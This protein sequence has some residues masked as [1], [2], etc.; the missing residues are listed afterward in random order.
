MIIIILIG[1]IILES[2]FIEK[3][4]HR[5][6]I[7]TFTHLGSTSNF[8]SYNISVASI[9]LSHIVG[10]RTRRKFVGSCRVGDREYISLVSHIAKFIDIYFRIN[11]QDFLFSQISIFQYAQGKSSYGIGGHCR[12]IDN[13]SKKKPTSLDQD[14]R[15]K[16]FFDDAKWRFSFFETSQSRIGENAS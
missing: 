5:P 16:R 1:K 12:N 7:D 9:I 10:Q 6:T 11:C 4:N 8:S 13:S 3:D 2:G 15:N 14:S